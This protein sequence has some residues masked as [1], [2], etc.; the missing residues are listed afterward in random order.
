MNVLVVPPKRAG[1]ADEETLRQSALVCGQISTQPL[2]APVPPLRRGDRAAL[3]RIG[4][5]GVVLEAGVLEPLGQY[6]IAVRLRSN[7]G[8]VS[9]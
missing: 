6:S 3:V 5:A 7:F 2:A 1:A 8:S 9:G 4:V